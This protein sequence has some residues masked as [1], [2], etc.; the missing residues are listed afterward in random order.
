ME[1][2]V[3]G[4]LT[5]AD[6]VQPGGGDEQFA[7]GDGD[8]GG[9]LGGPRGDAHGVPP[10]VGQ[11]GEQGPC[12]VARRGDTDLGHQAVHAFDAMAMGRARSAR[13]PHSSMNSRRVQLP[14]T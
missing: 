12:D 8:R 11:L 5:V 10:A 9:E 2:G 6:V 3:D 14:A 1:A 4:R 13:G 7:I